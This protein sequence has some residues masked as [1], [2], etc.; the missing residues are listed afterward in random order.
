M[1]KRSA[2]E[3]KLEIKECCKRYRELFEESWNFKT[4]RWKTLAYLD[5]MNQINRHIKNLYLELNKIKFRKWDKYRK[6][7]EI[8]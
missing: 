2:E 5:E 8:L 3:V 4:N 6:L 1:T 7:R